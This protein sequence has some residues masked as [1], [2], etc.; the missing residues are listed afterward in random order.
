[1][2]HAVIVAHPNEHSLT[3]SC[4]R[5]YAESALAHGHEVLARDLYG[6][7]F[8]PCLRSGEVPG[9]DGY[10]AGEDVR[11][12]REL[13]ADV[14]VFALFYPLWFNAPPAILKGY[15]DRV[16]SMGFGYGPAFGGTEPKLGGRK[17]ISFTFSGAPDHWVRETGALAAL[18]TLFDRHL[19]QVCGLQLVD[20]VHHGG[21]VDDL[22][23]EAVQE[24]LESIRQRVDQAFGTPAGAAA[25]DKPVRREL[26][27]RPPSRSAAV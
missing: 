1:M 4:A 9:R 26:F 12:E 17:L 14:D 8:D 7:R 27:S 11:R 18:M 25:S 21:I 20:H 19:A 15:V 13:L 22:T 6:M 16:F 10:C 3:L 23:P 2:K 5:A 24:I